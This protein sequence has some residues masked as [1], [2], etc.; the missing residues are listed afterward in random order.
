LKTKYKTLL[1]VLIGF[2]VVLFLIPFYLV[3]INSFK[4]N[5]ELLTNILSWPKRFILDNYQRAFSQ[6]NYTKVFI[7][8]LIVT[9][10]SNAGVTVFSAMAAYRLERYPTRMNKVI[11]L[12]LLSG[13]IIPFQVIMIP[14]MKV[15]K[16]I[17]LINSLFGVILTYWGMGIAF[18]VFLFRGFISSIPKEVEEAAFIDGS[19]LMY[20]FWKIVFPLLKPVI[21]TSVT[22]NTFWFWNDFLLPQ[23]ILS[24]K[25]LQTIPI[26]INAFFGQYVMKWDLALPALVMAIIPAVVVFICFQKYIV[27]GM[28][29]GAV[30]G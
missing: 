29:S 17:H 22:I 14:L 9:I 23:L 12:V 26:A 7:N 6:L 19:S 8:S 10:G 25:E 18:T 27:E 28:V 15:L 24:K 13:L 16:S 3:L 1:S 20:M 11:K 30:K 4:D 21:F 2:C 5:A